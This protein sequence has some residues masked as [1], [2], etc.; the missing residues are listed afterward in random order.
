[1]EIRQANGM[2]PDLVKNPVGFLAAQNL[3]HYSYMGKY[4]H[5]VFDHNHKIA[6]LKN[7]HDNLRLNFLDQ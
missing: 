2:I 5:R 7:I 1:M 3:F 6:P 4:S